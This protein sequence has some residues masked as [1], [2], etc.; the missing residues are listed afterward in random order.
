ME[1]RKIIS[2][3]VEDIYSRLIIDT[4]CHLGRNYNNSIFA[5]SLQRESDAIPSLHHSTTARKVVFNGTNHQSNPDFGSV[6][7]GFPSRSKKA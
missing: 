3:L 5:R 7:P 6:V 2:K 1:L 4:D